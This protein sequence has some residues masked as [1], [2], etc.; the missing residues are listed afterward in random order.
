MKSWQEILKRQADLR[1]SIPTAYDEPALRASVAAHIKTGI[2]TIKQL[3]KL[4][5]LYSIENITVPWG[6]NSKS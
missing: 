2:P 6:I 1:K 4:A 3:K 5:A